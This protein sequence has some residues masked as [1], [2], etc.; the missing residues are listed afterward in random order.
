MSRRNA[1]IVVTNQL[2]CCVLVIFV[3]VVVLVVVVDDDVARV[4][5]IDLVFVVL[6]FVLVLV[7]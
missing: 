4:F 5:V 2:Y 6:A 7:R 1:N 3:V